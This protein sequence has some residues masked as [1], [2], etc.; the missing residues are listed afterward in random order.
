MLG[1]FQSLK[2]GIL[3]KQV[4]Q[5]IDHISRVI[6]ITT[7]MVVIG[8]HG[9]LSL[10]HTHQCAMYTFPLTMIIDVCCRVC[11]DNVY[12]HKWHGPRKYSQRI[13]WLLS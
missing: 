10:H 13:T 6:N 9:S 4:S 5:E 11:A 2:S 7:T 12:T 3:Y 8:V 1:T